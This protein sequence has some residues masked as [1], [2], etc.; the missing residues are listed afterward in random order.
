V[1]EGTLLTPE[2]LGPRLRLIRMRRGL[3]MSAAGKRAGIMRQTLSRLERGEQKPMDTTLAKLAAA[4]EVTID[5]LLFGEEVRE[6]KDL[7]EPDAEVRSMIH[8]ERVRQLLFA[9]RVFDWLGYKPCSDG[10]NFWIGDEK[11]DTLTLAEMDRFTSVVGQL[12]QMAPLA[13]DALHRRGTPGP[14]GT[15]A[16]GAL[17]EAYDR[18]A[19]AT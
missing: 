13:T 17:L 7:D 10:E 16:G 3:S 1:A 4:Y 9:F 8:E 5:E 19:K 11:G 15:D 6:E 12:Q 14:E 2:S 18:W